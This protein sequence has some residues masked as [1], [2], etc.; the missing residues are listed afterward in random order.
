[1]IFF[2]CVVVIVL[3]DV[4]AAAVDVRHN[5]LLFLASD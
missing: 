2:V 1:M 4:I 5:P 3:I